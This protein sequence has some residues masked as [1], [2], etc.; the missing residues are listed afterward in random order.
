MISRYYN[1]IHSVC[2]LYIN[3]IFLR[4][5]TLNT[6]FTAKGNMIGSGQMNCTIK[7]HETFSYLFFHKKKYIY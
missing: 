3:L 6:N 2:F 7:N 4:I 5:N 1:Q